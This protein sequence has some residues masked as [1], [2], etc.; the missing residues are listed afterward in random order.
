MLHKKTAVGR[1]FGAAACVVVLASALA[2]TPALA[3]TQSVGQPRLAAPA[4]AAVTPV[5]Q[6]ESAGVTDH[7][8][9]LVSGVVELATCEGAQNEQWMEENDPFSS[10]EPAVRFQN[11][12]NHGCLVAASTVHIGAC[13]SD[14]DQK[15]TVVKQEFAPGEFSTDFNLFGLTGCL[16]QT[17]F[18]VKVGGCAFVAAD[19]WV[20]DAP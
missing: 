13:N 12:S 19:E 2:T 16:D 10:T 1:V 9:D 3:S 6:I 14:D 18:K 7:C 17:G 4:A 15:F 11:V 8:L 20:F 5:V